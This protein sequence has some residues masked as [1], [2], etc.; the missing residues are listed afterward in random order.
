MAE[1]SWGKPKIEIA[2]YVNG[3]LPVTPT[4]AEIPVPK[5]DSTQLTTTKGTQ[6]KATKEGG[7][8]V[9][10]RNGENGYT[11]VC[12][13]QVTRNFEKPIEDI[14]GV[15]SN[16]Y[17]VRLTPEDDTL[18]GFV[19]DKSTVSVEETYTA[20]DGKIVRYTFEGLTPASGAILKPYTKTP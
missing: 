1:I 12:D 7:G 13:L 4:W 5:E 14:N 9:D 19:M 20:A 18:E 16:H 3:A 11:L 6:K 8:V 2:P 17:A 10:V 15:V